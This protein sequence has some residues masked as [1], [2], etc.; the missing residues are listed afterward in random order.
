M[1]PLNI[2]SNSFLSEGFKAYLPKEKGHYVKHNV[3]ANV[4]KQLVIIYGEDNI[5]KPFLDN[6]EPL[7]TTNLQMYGYSTESLEKWLR[8]MEAFARDN[9]KPNCFFELIEEHLIDMYVYKVNKTKDMSDKDAFE[10]LLYTDNSSNLIIRLY[11]LLYNKN[12]KSITEYWHNKL[13]ELENPIDFE[14]PITF[15]DS[16]LY[17]AYG[18]SLEEVKKM[19]NKDI[20]KINKQILAAESS[21]SET[22]GGR[23]KT[24]DEAKKLVLMAN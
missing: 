13:Y 18:L 16:K 3:F 24:N 4:L 17:Q 8:A 7:F 14:K 1:E 22:S 21:G 15:L 10:K 2:F 19:P 20:E 6:N 23:S 9:K 5:I 11:N 12:I